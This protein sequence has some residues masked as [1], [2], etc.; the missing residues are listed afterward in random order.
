M[1]WYDRHLL[2]HL[3][4]CAC[5]MGEVMKLRSIL[6]PQA[7]GRVL[8]VGIGTGLNL[9]YYDARQVS[10]ICGLDPS[11][12][13]HGLA[14]TRAAGIQI[15]IEHVTL[16]A[17][18]I[19]AADHSYDTV[20]STFTL[21]TIPDAVAALGEMRRV[22]NPGGELLFC[23]HGKAPDASVRRWQDRLTPLWKPIAGGC[24]LNRDIP[25]LL[26]AGG[27]AVSQMTAGYLPGPRPM[28][29]V[30]RGSARAA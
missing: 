21:C 10:H 11:P 14:R 5:G 6:I 9:P 28:T 17:E 20:V 23:E 8:E 30:Y 25:A 19:A 16:S 22:L 18:R 1:N 7:K 12:E 26:A 15:P 13:M 3:I 27:F 4:D 24:H 29:Y 2:P